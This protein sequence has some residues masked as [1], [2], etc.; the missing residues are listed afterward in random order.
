[1]RDY[2]LIAACILFAGFYSGSETGLYCMNRLR[3]RLGVQRGSAA[4]RAVQRML[5]CPTLAISTM[6]IGTNLGLYL[7]TVLATE[8]I[9]QAGWAVHAELYSGLIMPPV[10]LIFAEVVPKSLFQHHADRLMG[11]AVW[12]LRLSEILF[13]PLSALLRAI[14]AVPRLLL[15]APAGSRRAPFTAEMFRFYLGA[16][17]AEGVLS[18]FQR[19]MA[20]NI[21][22]LELLRVE[23]VMTPLVESVMVPEEASGQALL[24]ALR[25]HRYSR[26][27]VYRGS[28]EQVVGVVNILDVAMAEGAVPSAGELARDA[29]SLPRWTSVAD[30]L[31][32]LRRERTQ[33]AVVSDAAGGAIGIVTVKDLV[34]EIVGELEAW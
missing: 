8:Q 22:H 2:L 4:A 26:I 7:A 27:P 18:S 14:S 33:F 32:Q 21:L 19:T 12:P 28:R 3:L 13:Y 34:E 11:G 5:A 31:A 6:L 23:A 17:A 20:E 25:P 1:M 24:E 9:R 30:A 15:K 10:L 16:G 29:V